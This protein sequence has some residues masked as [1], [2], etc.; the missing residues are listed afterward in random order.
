M[1]MSVLADR[2]ADGNRNRHWRDHRQS[3]V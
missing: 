2:A 3:C 1:P